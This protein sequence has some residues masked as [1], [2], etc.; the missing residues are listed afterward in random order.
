MKFLDVPQSGSIADRTHSHN[1]AGQ[2]TRNRRAPVQPIG[3]GR[4]AEIRA[5]FGTASAAWSALT[6]AQRN[7]WTSFANDHP[8]TDALGQAI[9]LTGHQMFVA[10]YTTSVNAGLGAVTVPPADLAVL[11]IST[12]TV[13]VSVSSGITLSA[14]GGD[15]T[16][17]VLVALSPSMSPGRSFT[18]QFNQLGVA[19]D[20]DAAFNITTA[21]YAAEFGTPVTGQAVFIRLRAVNADGWYGPEAIFKG[22]WGT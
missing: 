11:D 7:S 17:R 14:L 4:R 8:F 19:E 18:S 2:Y 13:T 22:I 9:K 21:V 16:G 1:R 10:V 20:D 5:A 6:E 12:T 15:G 3:N